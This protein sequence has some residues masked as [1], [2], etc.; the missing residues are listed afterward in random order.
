MNYGFPPTERDG[1]LE[2]AMRKYAAEL[3]LDD[4]GQRPYVEVNG[5]YPGC[6]L[7][8]ITHYPDATISEIIVNLEAIA[9]RILT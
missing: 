3:P 6:R 7:R 8:R 5:L 1:E 9:E 2:I 4:R